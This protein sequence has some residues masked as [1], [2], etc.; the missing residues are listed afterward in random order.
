M[1]SADWTPPIGWAAPR[2]DTA[3]QAKHMPFYDRDDWPG[4]VAETKNFPPTARYWTGLS[5]AAIEQLEMETVCGA[6]AG[7]PPLG[8]ELRMTPPGNK[9]RYLRDVGSLVGAS[10][11][12]ETTCIY[13]EYQ[14][15]G[16]V[17]GRPIN[18]AEIRLKMRHEP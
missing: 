7:G 13:V 18:D 1:P 2:W 17:H 9:K 10:G 15:C 16:S 11:G 14:T 5:P 6:A 12:V 4:I 3:E 8:I